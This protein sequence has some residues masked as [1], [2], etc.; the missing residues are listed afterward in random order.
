MSD[1][2]RQNAVHPVVL[3]TGRF[4]YRRNAKVMSGRYLVNG[5]R[6]IVLLEQASR[7]LNPRSE[8]VPRQNVI[9]C[10]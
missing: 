4:E 6:L 2:D 7:Y 3:H 10:E 9:R 8:V 1:T 5:R